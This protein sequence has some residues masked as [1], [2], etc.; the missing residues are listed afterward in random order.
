MR[1]LV[2]AAALLGGVV[3]LFAAENAALTRGTA[4]TDPDL[5]RKLDQNNTLTI[6][7][8]LSPE[9][10]SDVPLTTEPMFASLPQLKDI[11]P[12]DRCGIRPLYRMVQ[13]DLSG[14]DHRRR[15]GFRRTI[16][17]SG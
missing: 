1:I 4:I 16:V 7:R 15:R 11:L 2:A 3:S 14:R 12:A 9:R 5:L 8:L 13:G 10:N 17:R 6:S